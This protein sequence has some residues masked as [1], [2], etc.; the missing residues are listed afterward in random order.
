MGSEGL[1]NLASGL[2]VLHCCRW[3]TYLDAPLWGLVCC[4]VKVLL[5]NH[6]EKGTYYVGG[7]RSNP[8][9]TQFKV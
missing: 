1:R 2:G 8:G 7:P 5:R 3:R 9:F 4:W 6:L